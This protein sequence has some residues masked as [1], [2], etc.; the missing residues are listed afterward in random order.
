[1]YIA[2]KNH[3]EHKKTKKGYFR[4]AKDTD[5]RLR[6]EHSIIWENINGKIPLGMQIHHKDFDRGHNEPENLQLVTSLEHKRIH[7]GCILRDN[8]WYKPCKICGE[9]KECSTEFWYFSRGWINGKI[10]KLCFIQKSMQVRK[11]L[12]KKGWKRKSYKPCRMQKI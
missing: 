11:D 8:K 12:I 5:G 9:Y 6:F 2:N 7:S 4:F 1:V 10:C 3:M